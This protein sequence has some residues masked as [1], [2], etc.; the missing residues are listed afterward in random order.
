MEMT[1]KLGENGFNSDMIA[2][3]LKVVRSEVY[4]LVTS[5]SK[6]TEPSVLDD[7]SEDSSWL[8]FAKS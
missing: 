2:N 6:G 4:S 1:I 7:Y 8:Q 5:F 3:S